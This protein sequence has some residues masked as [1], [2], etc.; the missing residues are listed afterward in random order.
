MPVPPLRRI[1]VNLPNVTDAIHFN[2]IAA[3]MN[4]SKSQLANMIISE[5]LRENYKRPSISD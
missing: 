2:T 4:C 3:E 1:H 5:W